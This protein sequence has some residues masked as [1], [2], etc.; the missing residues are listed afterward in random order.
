MRVLH[1]EDLA[2]HDGS[3]SCGGIRKGVSEAL[4]G[5]CAGRVLSREKLSIRGAD[6]VEKSGRQYGVGRQGEHH[7]D[8]ARSETSCTHGSHLR[9]NREILWTAAATSLATV[10]IGKGAPVIR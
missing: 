7:S 8:P 9:G 6:A 2:S 1:V 3:E 10:R 5:E 4:T